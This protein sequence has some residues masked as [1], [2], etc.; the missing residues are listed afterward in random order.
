MLG[1]G[2]CCG[3]AQ[4]F[5]GRSFLLEPHFHRAILTNRT[6]RTQYISL[7]SAE[8][9]CTL[10]APAQIDPDATHPHSSSGSKYSSAIR[11]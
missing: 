7:A 4:R 5:A 3:A 6:I 9:R 10:D 1:G 8:S 11:P 2:A